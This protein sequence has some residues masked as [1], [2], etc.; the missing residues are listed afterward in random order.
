VS[1]AL[2]VA[3]DMRARRVVLTHFSQRYPKLPTIAPAALT[4]GH[5]A[6]D[7]AFDLGV[8]SFAREPLRA[9][10][11]AQ[12]ETLLRSCEEEEPEEEDPV[13]VAAGGGARPASS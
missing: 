3:A 11:W 5:L 7:V 4:L 2:R 10:Q 8:V 13:A 9:A 6:V 12:L 1:Q